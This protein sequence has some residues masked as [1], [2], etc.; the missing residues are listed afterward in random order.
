MVTVNGVSPSVVH[1]G[2]TAIAAGEL[3]SMVLKQDDTVWVTG[4][5]GYGQ[6]GDGTT[7]ARRN[8]LKLGPYGTMVLMTR[9]HRSPNS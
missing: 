7:T 9:T 8:V 2:A 1:V 6:F 4:N 5:N 3:H